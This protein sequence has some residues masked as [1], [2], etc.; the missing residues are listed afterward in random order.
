MCLLTIVKSDLLQYHFCSGIVAS[1]EY[2]NYILPTRMITGLH[3][4]C[5]CVC[6]CVC[7]CV[8]A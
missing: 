2:N 1:H 7:V 8:C 4:E 6:V 5:M 3:H